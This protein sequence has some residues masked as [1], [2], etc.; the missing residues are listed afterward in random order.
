[1]HLL[2]VEK[3]SLDDAEAAIDLSQTPAE[4]LFLSFSDSDLSLMAEAARGRP[5]GA[6]SMRL[7]NLALLKHPYSV[8]LYV[9]KAAN[10]ARFVLVR[11]LGGLDYWRYGVEELSRAARAMNFALAIVPGDGMADERLAA[12]STLGIGDLRRIHEAFQLGSSERISAL[13]EFIANFERARPAWRET[14]SGYDIPDAGLFEAG[15]REASNPKGQALIVFYRSFLIANDTAA[16]LAL[17]AA[18]AARG[19][20][21]RAVFVSSLKDERAIDF[22]C[23]ELA[24]R[25]PDVIINT[26]LFSARL[27]SGSSV[28]DLAG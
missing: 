7:A 1:M 3:R 16:I 18:L 26:T 21:V 15:C 19:L 17:A 9:E 11:L 10:H 14:E 8:D 4:I 6:M 22:I 12:A 23:A 13:F 27:N 5:Q 24:A 28:L 2:R 20:C 25:K